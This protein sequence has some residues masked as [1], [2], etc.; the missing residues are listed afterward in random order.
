[1]SAI[2]IIAGI[3]LIVSCVLIIVLV[4]LQSSKGSGLS[5][6]IGGGAYADARGKTKANEAKLAKLTKV[7]AVIFFVIT[8]AVNI[9]TLV[10]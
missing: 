1:M 5:G 2:E 4:M 7:F 8:L 6:A 10:A 9:V 3:L